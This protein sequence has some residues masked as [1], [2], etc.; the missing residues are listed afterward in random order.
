MRCVPLLREIRESLRPLDRYPSVSVVVPVRNE[1]ANVGVAVGP[2]LDQDY[3][4]RLEVVAVDGRSTDRTGE[5]IAGLAEQR[6]GRV[7][8]LRV[9]G[10][11]ECWL[12]KNHAL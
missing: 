10:L 9:D 11:P 8:P 4:G 3:P 1:E 12:G 5:L 2:I 6:P 7:N